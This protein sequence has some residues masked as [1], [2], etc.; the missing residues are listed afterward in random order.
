MT[1]WRGHRKCEKCQIRKPYPADFARTS[2]GKISRICKSCHAGSGSKLCQ[3]CGRKRRV[4]SEISG[5]PNGRYCYDC[6]RETDRKRKRDWVREKRQSDP[7]YAEVLRE[8]V[9][10]YKRQN[11]EVV[12]ANSQASKARIREDPERGRRVREN[13]RM[14]YR[15]R[16]ERA[17]RPMAELRYRPTPEGYVAPPPSNHSGTMLPVEP[18]ADWLRYEF[19]KWPVAEIASWIGV[20]DSHLS[21]ILTGQQRMISEVTIDRIVVGADCPHLLTLLY[22]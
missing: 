5:H 18:L 9:R 20:D 15:E 12:L 14:A 10:E 19:P 17:G 8:R 22:S 16:Q 7:E 6:Q 3:K 13:A 1:N 21:K 11:P 4:G 2:S